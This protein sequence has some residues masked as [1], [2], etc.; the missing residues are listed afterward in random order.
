MNHSFPAVLLGL[1]LS[2][3]PVTAAPFGPSPGRQR[4]QNQ[5]IS[6]SGTKESALP[7]ASRSE[8][9]VAGELLL[10]FDPSLQ[11]ASTGVRD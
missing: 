5:N 10:H 3:L 8:A 7:A 1:Q 9:A 2:P 6:H 11:C 4:D